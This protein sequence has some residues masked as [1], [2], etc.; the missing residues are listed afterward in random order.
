[1]KK[2]VFLLFLQGANIRKKAEKVC[3]TFGSELYMMQL[4]VTI[5]QLIM[6]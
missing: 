1:M 6:Y 3:E 5:S 4:D 2:N